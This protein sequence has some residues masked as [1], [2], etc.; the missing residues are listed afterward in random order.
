[1]VALFQPRLSQLSVNC[2]VQA[3]VLD[4]RHGIDRLENINQDGVVGLGY[5]YK[6]QSVSITYERVSKNP[7]AE[8][9]HPTS[10]YDLIEFSIRECVKREQRMRICSYCGKYFDIAM[11]NTAKFCNLTVDENGHICKVAWILV[12]AIYM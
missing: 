8:T 4:G 12:I 6:F 11:R 5:H 2:V 1:M 10:I 9:I 3:V 7:F